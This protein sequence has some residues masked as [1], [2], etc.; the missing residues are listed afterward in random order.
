VYGSANDEQVLQ[1]RSEKDNR[2]GRVY[3]GVEKFGHV[4][5]SDPNYKGNRSR[6]WGD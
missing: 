3:L 5:N 4:N 6:D 2:V 1:G